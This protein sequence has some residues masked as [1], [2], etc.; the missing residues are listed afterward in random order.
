MVVCY[1]RAD[2]IAT[3]APAAPARPAFFAQLDERILPARRTVLLDILELLVEA[4]HAW[5]EGRQMG[6][7]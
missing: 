6:G 1:N 4:L 2:L 5:L 7:S 3:S